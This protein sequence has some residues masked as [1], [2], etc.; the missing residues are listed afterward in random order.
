MRRFYGGSRDAS[1]HD[2]MRSGA[3]GTATIPRAV[4]GMRGRSVTRRE[5]LSR[6]HSA[7]YRVST[8]RVTCARSVPAR[9]PSDSD[10]NNN[11]GEA[12]YARFV[13][14]AA[15][16]AFCSVSY[17]DASIKRRSSRALF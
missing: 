6:A 1:V 13:L 15:G 4:T 12:P 14:Q 17:A 7:F 10:A 9:L 2:R 5:R 3:P 16:R 8:G 11:G